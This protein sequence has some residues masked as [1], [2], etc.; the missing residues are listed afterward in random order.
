MQT[1]EGTTANAK[2]RSRFLSRD[3]DGFSRCCFHVSFSCQAC[4]WVTVHPG[5]DRASMLRRI[6]LGYQSARTRKMAF[7]RSMFSRVFASIFRNSQLSTSPHSLACRLAVAL[8]FTTPAKAVF[9]VQWLATG[10]VACDDPRR[11]RLRMAN[12]R[13]RQAHVRNAVSAVHALTA[14]P[15]RVI[16]HGV[17]PSE[18]T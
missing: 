11:G 14:T 4:R 12:R 17:L 6:G 10:A 8:A 16:P 3:Q 13:T 2:Q 7:F 5:L 1:V 18:W 9:T 15:K